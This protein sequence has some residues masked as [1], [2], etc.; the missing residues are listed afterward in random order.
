MFE[1][2]KADN[3]ADM[4]KKGRS[5]NGRGPGEKSVCANGHQFTPENT[6]LKPNGHRRCLICKRADWHRWNDRRKA[7]NAQT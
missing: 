5:R 1:G 7:A 6:V 2:T 3:T 4:V